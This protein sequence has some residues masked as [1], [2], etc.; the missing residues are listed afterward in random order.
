LVLGDNTVLGGPSNGFGQGSLDIGVS[1]SRSSGY[2]ML[3]TCYSIWTKYTVA[4]KLHG[5]ILSDPILIIIL[6]I[7][8][9]FIFTMVF[10]PFYAWLAPIIGFSKEYE[11][12][13][14]KLWT[15]PIFYFVLLLIPLFSLARDIAWK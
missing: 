12:I 7:P 2:F 9:S 10:L 15:N 8:G 1:F 5:A 4:G 14:P 11:G 3:R 13:V 6:A